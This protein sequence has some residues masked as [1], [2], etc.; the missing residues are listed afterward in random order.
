MEDLLGSLVRDDVAEVKV[1]L[2][3]VALTPAVDRLVLP[4]GRPATT[5]S[6]ARRAPG[7]RA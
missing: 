3:S 7:A 2:S 6:A 5:R 1:V 4:G